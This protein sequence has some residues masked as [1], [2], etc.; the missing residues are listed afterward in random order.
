VI[1]GIAIHWPSRSFSSSITYSVQ[2]NAIRLWY[3]G[4]P[5]LFSKQDLAAMRDF[6]ALV[7]VAGTEGKASNL[8]KQERRSCHLSSSRKNA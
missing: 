8:S 6:G 3:E 5:C 4:A 7:Q 2:S 1:V